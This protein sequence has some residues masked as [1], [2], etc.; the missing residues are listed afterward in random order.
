MNQY[1]FDTAGNLLAYTVDAADRL[2]NGVYVIDLASGATRALDSK[3]ME[4][5][6]LAWR[7]SSTSLVALRGEKPKD[8]ELRANVLLAWP[9]AGS[10]QP[11]V[12]WDPAQ[13]ATFPK[14]FVLSEYAAPQ[15]SKDGARLFVGIKQQADVLPKN[16]ESKADVD[17]WHYD[18]VELQSQQMIQIGRL[19]RAT[20]ASAFDGGVAEV[21]ATGRHQHG[22]RHAHGRRPV[23]HRARCHAVR[24]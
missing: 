17:V 4:Y 23:G 9:D 13:D 8:K 22:Q 19:R 24:P 1:D 5:D 3:P 16:E 7:D 10:A 21:R 11:G 18:D 12:E 14:D 20:L 15:W 6:G 2:G